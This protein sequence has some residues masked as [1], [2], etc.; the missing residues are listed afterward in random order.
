MDDLAE[1]LRLD[2][3]A[4]RR[5]NALGHGDTTPSGQVLTHSA[6]LPQCL[7][8]LKADWDAALARVAAAQRGRAAAPARRRHRLHVVRL[9]QHRRC[10]THRPCASRSAATAR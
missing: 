10:R 9:R 6:G 4:I 2:R 7:D 3:W 8:A 1:R 5:I